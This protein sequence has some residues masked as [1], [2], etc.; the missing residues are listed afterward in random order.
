MNVKTIMNLGLLSGAMFFASCGDTT[1]VDESTEI[2][3]LAE[4]EDQAFQQ[5]VSEEESRLENY[6]KEISLK[7]ESANEEDVESLKTAKTEAVN[8]LLQLRA[9]FINLTDETAAKWVVFQEGINN[10]VKTAEE[11]MNYAQ[12][13]DEDSSDS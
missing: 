8:M 10:L 11:D 5:E 4:L 2:N 12:D 9:D 7:I 1:K 13:M 3:A 6:I